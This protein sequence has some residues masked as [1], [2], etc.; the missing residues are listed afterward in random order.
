MF[1][2]INVREIVKCAKRENQ[3]P[4]NKIEIRKL[5]KYNTGE[6]KKA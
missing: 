3:Q 1:A 4:Q 6:I 5:Q 2:K